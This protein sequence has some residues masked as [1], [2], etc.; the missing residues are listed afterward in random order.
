MTKQPIAFLSYVRSDDDHDSGRITE[1]RQR[2][3]G[4]VKIQTGEDFPIFQDRN[5]I[6]WGQVWK[7]RIETTILD[8]TFLIPIVTPTYFR[9]EMCRKE[10]ETFLIREN[11]LGEDRLILP[12]YY[13]QAKQLEAGFPGGTDAIADVLKTRNWADW[14]QYRFDPLSTPELKKAIAGM[15]STIGMAM[16]ELREVLRVATAKPTT[17]RIPL[18]PP[19]PLSEIEM[20]G[21]SPVIES[22]RGQKHEPSRLIELRS[23]NYFAYTTIFDEVIVPTTISEPSDTLKLQSLLVRRLGIS[24]KSHDSAIKLAEDLLGAMPDRTKIAVTILIDNS[25]SMRGNKINTVATWISIVSNVLQKMEIPHEILGFTTRAWKGGQSRELW[26][27]DGKPQSPGRLNDV[28]YLLYKEYRNSFQESLPN[29][30]IMLREGLLKENIDGEALLWARSRI[31]KQAADR[32]IVLV[33]SDGAPVDD[34]TLSE[35]DPRI[36]HDHLVATT[37]WIRDQEDI[38]LLGAGIGHDVSRYYGRASFTLGEDGFG[39]QLLGAVV[40]AITRDDTLAARFDPPTPNPPKGKG[41]TKRATRMTKADP[42]K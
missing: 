25:G 14:R 32:K 33:L 12:I 10:F 38:E 1:L 18:S 19:S 16:D 15:A 13:V 27:M 2:L 23:V 24:Q 40:R 17:E 29:F 26:F 36:L 28:R 31:L 11:A 41:P 22:A 9:S 21:Y 3:E 39:T 8:I 37:K 34:S 6:K 5:D 20:A 7:E 42:L 30:A 4:E 35:N